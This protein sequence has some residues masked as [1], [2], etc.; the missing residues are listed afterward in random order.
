MMRYG[1]QIAGGIFWGNSVAMLAVGSAF[2]WAERFFP[3]HGE[4]I[5]VA[6][7]DLQPSCQ[8]LILGMMRTEG[9]GYL[10]SALAIAILLLIPFRQGAPWAPWAIVSIGIVEHLP[11]FLAT[12]HVA[13]TTSASPPWLATGVLLV[14][15][16]CGLILALSE[17]VERNLPD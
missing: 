8:T 16:L 2:I 9:A 10:A 7:S 17:S 5:Q 4:V 12:F 3:F 15:L 14:S 6:W 1:H 13:R 11:T